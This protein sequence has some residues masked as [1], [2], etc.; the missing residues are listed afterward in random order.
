MTKHSPNTS[1]PSHPHHGSSG[2]E[3][4]DVHHF[5][6]T[7]RKNNDLTV[8]HVTDPGMVDYGKTIKEHRDSEKDKTN[9]KKSDKKSDE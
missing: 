3:E 8:P 2:Q 9:D 5:D 7:G 4:I 1:E 6:E